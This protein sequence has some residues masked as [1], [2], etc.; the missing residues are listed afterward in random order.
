MSSI[1]KRFLNVIAL[2]CTL[3]LL[4]LIWIMVTGGVSDWNLFLTLNGGFLAVAYGAIAA[5][6]Y[7]AFGVVTLWH[8]NT[9]ST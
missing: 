9:R 5:I 7:V 4:L 3:Y 6:N 1:I 8:R 2:V